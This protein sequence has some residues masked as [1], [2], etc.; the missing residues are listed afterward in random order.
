MEQAESAASGSG[1]QQ[2][3]VRRKA[4]EGGQSSIREVGPCRQGG[5]RLGN[6]GDSLI[7]TAFLPILNY[8]IAD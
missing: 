6:S 8:E 5:R 3:G 4:F 7:R 2:E 1:L